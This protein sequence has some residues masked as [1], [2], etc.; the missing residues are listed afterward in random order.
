TPRTQEYETE[1][2]LWGRPGGHF[3]H[4]L[5]LTAE[6]F[7]ELEHWPAALYDAAF[8]RRADPEPTN[9]RPPCEI[10]LGAG[11]AR[12]R[13]TFAAMSSL[14]ATLGVETLARLWMAL[15]LA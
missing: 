14:A 6:E 13:P 11:T 15:A 8:W 12:F 10:D 3:A 2:G 9:R 1:R 5:R 7:T 4:G